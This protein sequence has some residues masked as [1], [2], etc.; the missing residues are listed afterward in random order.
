M[1]KLPKCYG[2]IPARYGSTRFPG[3]PLAEII[4]KPMFWHVYKRASKCPQLSKI[5]LATDDNRI[6]SAANNLN[7]PTINTRDKRTYIKSKKYAVR[8]RGKNR[9]GK[10]QL[11]QFWQKRRF[12][13][14]D[15]CHPFLVT[16]GSCGPVAVY[17]KLL[18]GPAAMT[19]ST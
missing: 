12:K 9:V 8:F 17:L 18:P 15:K 16:F 10:L 6:V 13:A 3:K 14:S 4:G 7:V 2:I 5:V 19:S 1:N 11:R